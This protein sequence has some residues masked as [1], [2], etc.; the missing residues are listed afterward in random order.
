MRC[1]WYLRMLILATH[2]TY[3]VRGQ[4]MCVMNKADCHDMYC[5]WGDRCH[6][7]TVCILRTSQSKTLNFFLCSRQWSDVLAEL[8]L[9][10]MIHVIK[11]EMHA[12]RNISFLIC[13]LCTWPRH[14]LSQQVSS[15]V[16]LG[17]KKYPSSI[18]LSTLLKL[19]YINFHSYLYMTCRTPTWSMSNL[20][21]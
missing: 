10:T 15:R 4:I 9:H 1:M 19:L 13:Y 2:L 20:L 6:E 12:I 3:V 7:S 17:T 21:R 14:Y 11:Y 18:P 8:R 16:P 5:D